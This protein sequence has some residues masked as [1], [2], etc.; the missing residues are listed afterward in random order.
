MDALIPRMG[1][2][3][4]DLSDTSAECYLMSAG[5]GAH[6]GAHSCHDAGICAGTSHCMVITR[7][8]I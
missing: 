4:G 7:F 1:D 3:Q 2:F 5:Y 8:V 6:C